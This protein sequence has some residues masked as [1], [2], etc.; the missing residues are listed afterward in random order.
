MTLCCGRVWVALV[1]EVSW[2]WDALLDLVLVQTI[3]PH[4]LGWIKYDPPCEAFFLCENEDIL[5]DVE[6]FFSTVKDTAV[7][8]FGR[9]TDRSM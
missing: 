6:P 3:N 1:D 8:H 4:L 5:P 9:E 2:H 7:R